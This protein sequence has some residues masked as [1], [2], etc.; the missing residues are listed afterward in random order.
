MFVN[1]LG[2]VRTPEIPRRHHARSPRK[3]KE[4]S[5]AITNTFFRRVSSPAPQ[6]E[7][8]LSPVV[9]SLEERRLLAADMDLITTARVAFVRDGVATVQ[10]PSDVYATRAGA[11]H[12]SF[13]AT[14]LDDPGSIPVTHFDVIDNTT[15]VVEVSGRTGNSVTLSGEGDYS[16][17]Y[18]S[19]DADDSEPVA[20]HTILIAIDHSAPTIAI[21]TVSPDIL[22]PPNGKFVNVTVAG[23]ASDF[24]S[25]VN[26]S[27]LR[28]NVWDEYHTVEPSGSI[29]NIAV[30][31]PTSFA[32]T[33][34]SISCSRSPSRPGATATISMVASTSSTCLQPTRPGTPA[35]NPRSCSYLTTWAASRPGQRLRWQCAAS[36]GHG[37]GADNGSHGNHHH[38]N[39]GADNNGGKGHGHT[40]TVTRSASPQGAARRS[41]RTG[42]RQHDCSR[43]TRARPW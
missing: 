42:R 7:P 17:Q 29:T 27:S 36:S 40:A 30:A 34:R 25:G 20:A 13:N 43:L 9:T 19:T 33:S 26:P 2:R 35:S 31:H 37:N 24:I 5:H 8:P 14:D 1:D 39:A 6:K 18:W 41:N 38:N 28:F 16:V 4:S 32:A 21:N 12:V 23:V 3:V 10:P 11:V 15:G 22:W